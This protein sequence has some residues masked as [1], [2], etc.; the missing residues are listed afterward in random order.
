MKPPV[1]KERRKY[2]RYDTQAEV[3]FKVRY[4]LNTKVSFILL[5]EKPKKEYK[6]ITCNISV[7]GLR[8]NSPKKLKMGDLLDIELY[9]PRQQKPI[10]LTAEVRWS[11]KSASLNYD[12]GVKLLTLGK[13]KVQDTIY[14]D[15]RYGVYWSIVLE[16]IFGSFRKVVKKARVQKEL[17]L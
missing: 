9:L 8:F 5:K 11:K 17:T 4:D 6:G 3:F 16:S 7:E 15:M 1:I 13:E 2:E 12:T 14:F 10:P